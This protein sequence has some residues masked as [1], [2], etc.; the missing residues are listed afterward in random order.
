MYKISFSMTKYVFLFPAKCVKIPD[1]KFSMMTWFASPILSN[2]EMAKL[3]LVQGGDLKLHN[4]FVLHT[5]VYILQI[6]K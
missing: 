3:H 1:F 2:E 5:D 6:L 4:Y